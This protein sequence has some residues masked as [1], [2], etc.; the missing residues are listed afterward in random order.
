VS[1]HSLDVVPVPGVPGTG[2]AVLHA[3]QVS[4]H[5][6]GIRALQGA[7]ITLRSG[8]IHGLIG[9]N[10]SGKSTL[11]G[12]LSGQTV[13]DEASVS[14]DGRE[15][16]PGDLRTLRSH[17]AIVTQELSLAP[18]LTVAENILMSHDKPRT[19]RG[20]DWK[21]LN[22][23]AGEALARLNLDIDP[24]RPVNSLRIDQQQL[25]EIAKAVQLGH[26]VLILDEPTSSL[27]EDAVEALARTMRR[28][29]ES[30]TAVVFVSHRLDELFALTDRVTVLR[31]G[32]TVATRPTSEY[33]RDSLVEDMLGY[34]VEHYSHEALGEV[35]STEPLMT[36]SR[37]S[38]PGAVTDVSF[39]VHPGEVVG[40]VGL[41]G[42]GR[43]ELLQ[44]IFGADGEAT[45]SV[46]VGGATSLP[47][48][49]LD[50]VRRGLALVPGDRKTDGLMLDLTIQE[51][52]NVA[53]TAGGWRLRPRRGSRE[54]ALTT[55]ITS[56]LAIQRGSNSRHAGALSGGNQQKVL[57]AKWILTEP[58]VMLL[59]EPTRGV[60]VGAKREIHNL[61]YDLRDRGMG[62]VVSSSDVE[63][64]MLLCD[65]FIVMFRGRVVAAVPRAEATESRLSHLATGGAA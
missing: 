63:E 53:R 48:S 25:V 3:A 11:L 40:L 64:L 24:S 59:D 21:R 16:A 37:V 45:G 47:R 17:V 8:E 56:A 51:N 31:D 33:T 18:D 28:L 14:I 49:P 65:R 41:E 35:S 43:S 44:A 57:L 39:D 42:A 19:W 7:S 10:G 27:T 62:I 29:A 5:Y 1:Q 36:V 54:A 38:V 55:Q 2:T 22:A 15:L 34:A 50:A 4:K 60:D 13:P 61:V 46:T 52:V 32:R 6:G 12:V 26:P 30:G 20:I 23:V 9:E 58:T